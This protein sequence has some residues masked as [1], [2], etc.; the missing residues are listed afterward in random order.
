MVK[1]RRA[2]KEEE[3]VKDLV[4]TL[5]LN[6][7]DTSRVR[8]VYS[9]G[10]KTKAIAR[11]WAIPRAITTAFHLQPVY[12]IELV[13]EM[14]SKLDE[15]SKIKVL[16]HELLHIPEKFSGGL[17]PHGEKVNS[18]TVNMLYKEYVKQKE[19]KGDE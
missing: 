19:E 5:G 13:S 4:R 9:S 1:Y 8:V 16:I 2:L 15:N 11:I 6:Y 7:I 14:F 18:R 12:V 10:A 3:M 17:R